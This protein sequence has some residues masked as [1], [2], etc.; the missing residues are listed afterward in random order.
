MRK[1]ECQWRS[2]VAWEAGSCFSPGTQC[3]VECR[4]QGSGT[5][6]KVLSCAGYSMFQ[7]APVDLVQPLRHNGGTNH[8]GQ[9]EEG[10]KWEIAEGTQAGEEGRKEVLPVAGAGIPL[11]PEK[12]TM[13]EQ[14]FVLW[15]MGSPCR[16]FPWRAAA[17]G[18]SPSWCRGEWEREGTVERNCDV[19]TVCPYCT[20]WGGVGSL[21]WSWAWKRGEGKDWFDV[22]FS[23]HGCILIGN[24]FIFPKYWVCFAHKVTGKQSSCL[25]LN[26]WAFSSCLLPLHC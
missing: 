3:C 8:M 24:K 14:V 7:L 5:A 6:G 17:C 13:R 11:Q 9:R 2:T 26:P 16:R 22:C 18:G 10:K 21:E 20:A 1:N 12:E 15:P 19:L 4:R 25:Q 23:W